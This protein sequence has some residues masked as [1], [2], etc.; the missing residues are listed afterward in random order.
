MSPE[1]RDVNS[2][3]CDERKAWW[4]KQHE[5]GA[6]KDNYNLGLQ[7]QKGGK[8]QAEG[9]ECAKA[10]GRAEFGAPRDLR[11]RQSCLRG[12]KEAGCA[13]LWGPFHIWGDVPVAVGSHW[14]AFRCWVTCSVCTEGLGGV[15][16]AALPWWMDWRG[17][18]WGN[19]SSNL[20]RKIVSV[21]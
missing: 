7:R 6:L 2:F 16:W 17:Q 14:K 20:G 5:K 13:G 11:G 4:R 1:K 10:W 21:K 15:T 19:K 12:R 3:G 18:E 8:F 9:A